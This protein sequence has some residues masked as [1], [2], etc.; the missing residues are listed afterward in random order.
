MVD[1]L[2]EYNTLASIVQSGEKCAQQLVNYYISNQVPQIRSTST[3]TEG[4][5]VICE[6]SLTDNFSHQNKGEYDLYIYT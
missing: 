4:K 2:A 1:D 6:T 3:I 5:E